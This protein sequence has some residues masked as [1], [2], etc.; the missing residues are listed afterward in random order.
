MKSNS[1]KSNHRGRRKSDPVEIENGNENALHELFLEELADIHSAEKQLTKALPKMAKAAESTEVTAAFKDHL[2]ET[3]NQISRIEKVFQSL[4]EP[5]KRKKCKGMEGLLKEGNE[6]AEEMGDT[7]AIDA[8]L[9]ASAQKVEHYEIA[10]YGT[11]VA[12]A[13]QMGHNEAVDLLTE[14][15]EEEKATDERLTRLAETTANQHAEAVA[16]PLT[17]AQHINLSSF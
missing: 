11:L 15:L 14:N 13:K 12:W 10:T 1:T 4:D 7:P 16:Q 9:I 2:E 8:T 17:S 5:V 6:M 3:E